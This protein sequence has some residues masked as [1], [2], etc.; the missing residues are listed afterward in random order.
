MIAEKAY[1]SAANQGGNPGNIPLAVNAT[2]DGT[3]TINE[4]GGIFNAAYAPH[5]EL[6]HQRQRR[7]ALQRQRLYPD[8]AAADQAVPGPHDVQAQDLGD[9]LRVLQ[10]H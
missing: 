6:E 9:D 4:N 3:V 5:R 1:A 2:N 7:D 10:R 8:D